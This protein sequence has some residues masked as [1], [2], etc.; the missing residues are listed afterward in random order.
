MSQRFR[1]HTITNHELCHCTDDVTQYCHVRCRNPA[2]NGSDDDCESV[3]LNSPRPTFQ[4]SYDLAASISPAPLAPPLAA[5]ALRMGGAGAGSA[6]T[7][8][9]EM[10]VDAVDP[11]AAMVAGSEVEGEGGEEK[12]M[13]CS[14]G[15]ILLA[16][17]LDDPLLPP[18][19]SIMLA[20]GEVECM[21]VEVKSPNDRL[22][23]KQLI[24]L[25][26]L[27]T[28]G[29]TARVCHVVHCGGDQEVAAF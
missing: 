4:S 2:D 25:H 24:W 6:C 29:A 5:V 7:D 22:S 19:K 14:M 8:G 9:R 15:S 10:E 12:G 27:Q 21:F 23:E 13:S 26:A 18:I 28:M 1:Q 16:G 17:A 20:A 3:D 11:D